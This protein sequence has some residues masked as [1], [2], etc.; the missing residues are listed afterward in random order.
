MP[1]QD[2]RFA[3]IRIPA[4]AVRLAP[5]QLALPASLRQLPVALRVDRG[6]PTRE[7]VV[8]RHVPD[9]AV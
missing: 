6:L 9:R 8:R 2:G 4:S 3:A 1:H 5:S 7:H